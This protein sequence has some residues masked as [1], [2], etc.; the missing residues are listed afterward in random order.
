MTVQL[1]LA[2]ASAC[3]S[4]AALSLA[5]TNL[6]MIHSARRARRGGRS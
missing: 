5:I 1:V 4:A 3:I 6:V 2:I